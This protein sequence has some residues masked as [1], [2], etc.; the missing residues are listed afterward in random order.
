M[1]LF[2]SLPPLDI[3][4]FTQRGKELIINSLQASRGGG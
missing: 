3:A 2:P 4:A 1:L